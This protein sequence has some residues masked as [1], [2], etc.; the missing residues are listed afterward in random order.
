MSVSIND[1]FRRA[2]K[3]D[4]S[5]LHIV[6]G[7]KPYLRKN[8]LLIELK[9][10]PELSKDISLQLLVGIL[11]HKQRQELIDNHEI[12]FSYEAEGVRF[13]VNYY[14]TKGALAGAFRL[15]PVEIKSLDQLSLPAELEK[16]TNYTQGL[17]LVT[18][19]TGQGKSTTLASL[20]N[21]INMRE[22]KH[23]ITIEDPIEYIYPKN[24]SIITQ[25]EVFSD[26]LSWKRALRAVLREDP[27]IVLVG[28]MRDYETISLVLTIAETGHLVFSTLH[29]STAPETINRIIDVFPP[30]Q[31]NQI[32]TQ[33]AENL[34]AVVSQV[35]VPTVDLKSR[36]PA[37]EI[38][39]NPPA[40]ANTIREGKIH[41]LQNIIETSEREGF[42]LLEKYLAKLYAEGKIT[43][44]V[45]LQH[46]VRDSVIRNYIK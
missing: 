40:V 35:L 17:V 22:S 36:V 32:R 33:L 44:D 21:H 34:K 45:A 3:E 6:P 25:R 1:L 23:I 15:I 42:I 13:R 4:A 41:Y 9:E 38:M 14:F 7:Y 19:R 43:R 37:L 8:S 11:N 31:Q 46:S 26:T 20:I 16:L 27:D 28:E 18:G 10:F 12:D 39:Y 29:T 2:I 30:S 24:L 5:D